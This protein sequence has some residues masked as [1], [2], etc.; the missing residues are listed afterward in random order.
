MYWHASLLSAALLVPYAHALLRFP[1]AQLVT[2]RLDPLV[3][4]GVISPHVHQIIG[5]NAFNF[6][7]RP[8]L[9][10]KSAATCTTC[11]FKEDK[12][13]YWTAVLYFKHRNGSFSR[14]FRMIIGDPT[15]RSRTITNGQPEGNALT[16]RCFSENFG[17]NTAAPGG[18]QDTVTMP[19]GA[20]RG[21]IRT[22]IYFPSC[23]DGKTLDPP[24]HHSHVA[25]A[26]GNIQPGGL[27]FFQ[28]TCPSSHPVRIPLILYETVWDTRP[29]LNEWPTDG[30]QPLVYSMGDPTG[31]GQHGDYLFG[32]EDDSLQRAMDTCTDQG[33]QPESC[34]ALTVQSDSQINACKQ[35]P[36]VDEVVEG[37]ALKE[38][39]G[40]NPVQNGPGSATMVNGAGCGGLTATNSNPGPTS[41][42]VTTPTPTQTQTTVITPTPT[43]PAGQLIP[44]YGQ[45][46]GNGWSGGTQCVAG[47]V[48]QKLNDWYSQYTKA[49]C[50]GR[51]FPQIIPLIGEISARQEMPSLVTPG[52]I[53]PHVHQIIGGVPQ[54]ANQ[55][56]GS[57]NGGMTVYYIQPPNNQKVTA[58]PKGFR[59][60]VGDPMLRRGGTIQAG[61]AA[62]N[63]LTFRCFSENFGGNTAAPGGGTDTNQLPTRACRG[64][65]RSNIY[66]PACWDGKSL[67]TA[68][69]HS[70]VAFAQGNVQ[71]GG[72]FFFGGTCPST[73]P[74]RIPLV[75]YEIVWDTR[76]FLNSWPTDG[77]QPLVFSMGDPTGFGQHGDYLFGWDGDSLQR[78]MDTCTDMGGV[79]E[80]CRA[81]TVLSD[82]EIN[83]C[84]QKPVLDEVVEGSYIRTLPGCNPIQEGPNPATMVNSC[85][86][87]AAPTG[88]APVPTTTV[89]VPPNPTTTTVVNPA[90]TAPQ[91]PAI[92]KYGQCGGNGWTGSTTC[93]AGSTC[94]KLNDWYSQCN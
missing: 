68:D 4:P 30:S 6:S 31:Y 81:L 2:Q 66:F 32:W 55:F 53:S 63:A 9:D 12:S 46:G 70:H 14:G 60:I 92:P 36:V 25:F 83:R 19:K 82:A 35:R 43:A 16:F 72:L 23:W 59:M 50:R 10:I 42:A 51:L 65:I 58:F 8:E 44:K 1:C 37:Q 7:M 40:C 26:T 15:L 27:F 86:G 73:H 45:C 18:G 78:A 38:L 52:I 77:S 76:P 34:R 47:S 17:G 62:A 57:P 89:V 21:G 3:T 49:S 28:G 87:T 64:G 91:G 74:V 90:P 85:S 11:R 94:V 24:D 41:T 39:P 33:G 88:T 48:C 29:F 84:T 54:M 61:S 69:H 67:D 79:P 20:C 75:L 71:P 56:T 93:V 22:N 13:N 80:Q 5:G